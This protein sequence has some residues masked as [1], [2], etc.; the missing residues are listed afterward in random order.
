MVM[1]GGFLRRIERAPQVITF[2]SERLLC[3]LLILRMASKGGLVIR[4]TCL[5]TVV[6]LCQ[7]M[8]EEHFRSFWFP[9]WSPPSAGWCYLIKA[10]CGG[11]VA[12]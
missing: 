3:R 12:W 1:T 8:P 9:S 10:E 5:D 7:P 6:L 2:G 4:R 11:G